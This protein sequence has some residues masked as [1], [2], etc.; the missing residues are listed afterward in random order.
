MFNFSILRTNRGRNCRKKAAKP[1][2]SA[3]GTG[4]L[5]PV[6]LGPPHHCGS[7]WLS[8]ELTCF[9]LSFRLW[10]ALPCS[11]SA[12]G[13]LICGV[14][15]G[16]QYTGRALGWC[17][18]DHTG[19]G[20]AFTAAGVPGQTPTGS[21]PISCQPPACGPSARGCLGSLPGV[22]L[23]CGSWSSS[24][25]QRGRPLWVSLATSPSS[26]SIQIFSRKF[27]GPFRL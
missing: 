2:L 9:P 19:Q 20:A 5:C 16:D 15:R 14:P 4:Q 7:L 23:G 18:G 24:F 25:H 26:C 3:L 11:S 1:F 21:Y 8:Q 27:L 17:P 13:G 22:V 10:L 12:R 6:P